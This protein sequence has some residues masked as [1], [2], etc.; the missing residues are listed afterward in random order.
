MKTTFYLLLAIGALIA[1]YANI[2]VSN[3]VED[4]PGDQDGNPCDGARDRITEV[5]TG[6]VHCCFSGFMSKISRTEF[7]GDVS[8]NCTCTTGYHRL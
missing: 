5:R 4:Y 7:N 3:C 1:V 8:V 6:M 2:S